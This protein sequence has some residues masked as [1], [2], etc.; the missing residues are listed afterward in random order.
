[1]NA[2]GPRRNPWMVAFVL[3][4]ASLA[5]ALVA[6]GVAVSGV[7]REDDDDPAIA[8]TVTTLPATDD[9]LKAWVD[10]AVGIDI[11]TLPPDTFEAT[12]DLAEAD[13]VIRADGDGEAF[14]AGR[15]VVVTAMHA[16]VDELTMAQVS[17]LLTGTITDWGEVG[18]VP[19]EASAALVQAD[20][21]WISAAADAGAPTAVTYPDYAALLA[22]MTAD[23]GIVSVVPL[24]RVNVA[25]RAIE[26][27]GV[28][29]VRGVGS[30]D[31]WPLTKI[32]RVEG[33][34]D[35]GRDVAEALAGALEQPL[36]VATTVIA[37]GDILINRCSL[38]RVEATGDWGAA[39]RTPVGEYL[40]SADLTLGQYD[41][42]IQDLY[43]VYR[44]EETTN[45]SSPPDVIESLTAGG[46]DGL[47]LATNH[48]AD[49]GFGAGCGMEALLRT[50]ELLEG[51]GIVT[52]GAGSTLDEA[53]APAIFDVGGV[54]YG[55]LGLDDVAASF[56]EATPDSPGTAPLDDSYADEIADGL[57]Y[58]PFFGT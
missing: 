55:V 47:S 19:G 4:L 44:C 32:A 22:A 31:S 45:L 11:S 51:A 46:I 41:G 17:G 43:D 23:S 1:M 18:G 48:I 10:P 35:D 9:P 58:T 30:A 34:T 39:L 6:L 36:P 13:V 7:M 3:S 54:R 26:V 38:A 5:A 2:P 25:V 40:A 20:A 29:I 15:W 24:D 8:V 37:T 16:G 50:I 28:D 56:L 53:L 12:S 27:D 42:S 21:A 33:V 57:Y 52:Y 14:V 49:C